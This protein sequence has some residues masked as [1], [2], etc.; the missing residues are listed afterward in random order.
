MSTFRRTRNELVYSLFAALAGLLGF[1]VVFFTMLP[2]LALSVT[3]IFTVV[4]LALVT[5]SLRL[6]GR[7]GGLHRRLL[8]RFLGEVVPG[9]APLQQGNGVLNRVD[10]R[11][12]HKPDWRAVLF[13]LVKFPVAVVQAGAISF[14]VDGLVDITYPV[15]WVLFRNHPSGTRL[16]P[17]PTLTPVGL[18]YAVGSWPDTLVAALI[19]II[20]VCVG[21]GVS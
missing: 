19:G 14:V 17:L 11:L 16:R 15:V 3:V 4:G 2:G 6:A 1:V 7:L 20:Y 5:V 21:I 8:A 18:H 13:A 12:R 10:N 9:P